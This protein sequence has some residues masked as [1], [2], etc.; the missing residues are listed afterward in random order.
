MRIQKNESL[1]PLEPCRWQGIK[2][3]FKNCNNQ[4]ATSVLA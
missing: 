3:P 1:C 2:N 4:K